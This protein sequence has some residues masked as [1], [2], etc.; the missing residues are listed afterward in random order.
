[1]QLNTGPIPTYQTRRDIPHSR[2]Q[3]S[4]STSSNQYT[5]R[6][7]RR[8]HSLADKCRCVRTPRLDG[9]AVAISCV[10]C[11]CRGARSLC[12]SPAAA[13]VAAASLF[14]IRRRGFG[15]DWLRPESGIF[16]GTR[17]VRNDGVRAL[18]VFG[19]G[20]VSRGWIGGR[21]CGDVERCIDFR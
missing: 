19:V 14:R 9:V 4:R 7:R 20:H 18:I 2:H 12:R 21:G 10:V 6:R 16:S 13:A 17:A 3:P 1:M 11:A 8:R 15:D 5:T